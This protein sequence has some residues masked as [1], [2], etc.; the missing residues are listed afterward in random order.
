MIIT[1]WTIFNNIY[2]EKISCLV[3]PF[4]LFQIIPSKMSEPDCLLT[5]T[6]YSFQQFRPEF[7]MILSS[8]SR[9]KARLKNDLCLILSWL[10]WCVVVPSEHYDICLHQ[11]ICTLLGAFLNPSNWLVNNVSDSPICTTVF[12]GINSKNFSE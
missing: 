5:Q 11:E 6:I 8:N 9:W 4:L 1:Y 3:I 10:L 2:Y 7:S 12:H